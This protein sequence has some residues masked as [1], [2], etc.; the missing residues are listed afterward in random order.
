MDQ[1][2]LW[3]AA[4]LAVRAYA[5]DPTERNA[6][7]VELAWERLREHNSSAIWRQR[8]R[9]WLEEDTATELKEQQTN[10]RAGPGPTERDVA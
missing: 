2:E 3:V 8:K 4:R 5:R 6:V 9:R 1:R 7:N 10:G